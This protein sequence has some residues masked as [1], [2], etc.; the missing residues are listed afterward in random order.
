MHT[1]IND[2]LNL[3]LRYNQTEFLCFLFNQL[4]IDVCSP[5][6]IFDLVC[7]L[8]AQCTVATGELDDFCIFFY[9]CLK[10]LSGN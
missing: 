8:I 9:Q 10:I 5:Y 1:G 3:S 7:L 2:S 6:F 4:I